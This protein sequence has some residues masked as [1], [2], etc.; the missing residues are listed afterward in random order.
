[1]D[2]RDID[3]ILNDHAQ[4]QPGS[5]QNSRVS[6]HLG[7][8]PQCADSWLASEA[9]AREKIGPYPPEARSALL[10]SVLAAAHPDVRPRRLW[11]L[12]SVIGLAAASVLAVLLLRPPVAPPEAVGTGA[13]NSR[14]GG[15]IDDI[16]AS[17]QMNH[18]FV[19]GVNYRVL[20]DPVP[21][22]TAD[23]IEVCEF[24]MF[25]C[26]HCFDLEQ[27]LR[28]WY[29]QRADVVSLRRVPAIWN[30][31]T[32]LQAQA[33]FTARTLGIDDVMSLFF[34]E[35]HVKGG[36]PDSIVAIRELFRRW[37][38]EGSRFDAVFNSDAVAHLMAEAVD[39]N[40]RYS[41]TSTPALAVDGRFVTDAGMAGGSYEDLFAV[42]DYLVEAG[43]AP[44]CAGDDCPAEP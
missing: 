43:H 11:R 9:L 8:C 1:M 3:R 19:D 38:V 31:T 39:L 13:R 29:R 28:S 30:E 10:A 33:F 40:R 36:H 22:A 4:S 41:I 23:R 35:I 16:P 6:A 12:A 17:R 26:A 7:D 18:R 5:A 42:M 32:R 21:T 2:C 14:P 25:P 20:R 24:F 34:D 15:L 44:V 27:P 37:G